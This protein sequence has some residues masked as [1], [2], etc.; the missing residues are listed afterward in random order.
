[1]DGEIVAEYTMRLA[2]DG[3]WPWGP[4]L[5]DE[6]PGRQFILIPEGSE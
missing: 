6:F 5:S 1:M 4:Y 2:P 3:V